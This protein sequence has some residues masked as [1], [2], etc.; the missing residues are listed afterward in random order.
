LARAAESASPF[1][2]KRLIDLAILGPRRVVTR[3]E[4]SPSLWRGPAGGGI[5]SAKTEPNRMSMTSPRIIEADIDRCRRQL[6]EVRNP[7]SA[8]RLRAKLAIL[9]H[10][11]ETL[12]TVARRS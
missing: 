7:E 9:E 4:M 2:T 1:S 8:T 11:F 6:L 3:P 5:V 10:Q 12:K